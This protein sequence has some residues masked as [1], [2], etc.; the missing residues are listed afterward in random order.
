MS[1]YEVPGRAHEAFSDAIKSCG[2]FDQDAITAACRVAVAEELRRIVYERMVLLR[3]EKSVCKVPAD[4]CSFCR[5][6]EAKHDAFTMPLLFRAREL[7]PEGAT[8]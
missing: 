1:D 3:K 5:E 4:Q 2:P 7:D 6:L 8:R